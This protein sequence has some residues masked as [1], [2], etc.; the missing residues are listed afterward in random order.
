M[1]L[2]NNK[3]AILNTENKTPFLTFPALSSIPFIRHGFSTRLGGVSKGYFESM[4]LGYSNGDNTE[5]VDEN[6]RRICESIGL[7]M[8]D[9]VLSHQVHNTVVRLVTEADKGKGVIRTRDYEGVDGLITNIPGIPL[10]TFSAD[11]VILY[12]VDTKNHAIGLCHSGWR[13]TV[14]RMGKVTLEAMREHFGTNSKDVVAV[15]GP[16][17]CMDCYEVSEDV[18][19]AFKDEFNSTQLKDMLLDKGNH[20]YQLDLWEANKHILL[21]AGMEEKNIHISGVCTSCNKDTLF[22]HRATQG[23]RGILAAFLMIEGL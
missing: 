10:V 20:K 13:G 7:P 11:C 4:N 18:A 14:K 12:L 21:D 6:Y 23:K 5:D 19:E 2:I 17:I 15:I 22:S 16:S 1:N 3:N 9:C 8:K